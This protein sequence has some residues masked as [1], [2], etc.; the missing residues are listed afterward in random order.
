MTP[1]MRWSRLPLPLLLL[2][3]ACG[4][5]GRTPVMVY[6]P[7]GPEILARFEKLFEEAHPDV[8]VQTFNMSSG[9]CLSRLR[10]EAKN[11]RADVFWGAT[12]PMHALA[13]E[14]DLL[15]PYRPT[16]LDTVD[17]RLRTGD[18]RYQS[19]FVMLQV[20]IYNDEKSTA[21]QAPD[22]WTDLVSERFDD[23]VILRLPPPS[24]TMRGAFSWLIS[25][26]AGQNDGDLE[27]GFE[28]LR[29]LHRNTKRYAIDPEDLF[30]SIQRED[31]AVGIWNMTDAMFQ[32]AQYSYP[33]GVKIPREGVPVVLDC[34]ALV[35]KNE[36]GDPR[37]AEMARAFY[38]FVTSIDSSVLL[39]DHHY[40]V[41]T[42]QD[43]PDDRKPDWLKTLSFAPL[44]ADAALADAMA[45]EWMTW[46]DENVKS[47]D[48]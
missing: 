30:K 4:D 1:P 39:I 47:L 19:Q 37:R 40:R 9:D 3:A 26:M 31:D 10:A 2:L 46:W 17:E 8:D 11:P 38:E 18:D 22:G 5:D 36:G 28:Y 25:W 34:I 24:G 20:I 45:D 7:H 35:K 27:T 42:R 43:I 21:D 15:Q 16:W 33:L 14:A 29:Q 23:R 6:S 12:A 13:A 41:P 44:P 48:R 32:K